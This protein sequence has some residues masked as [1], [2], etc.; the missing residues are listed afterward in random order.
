[1]YFN[2]L[3][4]LPTLTS[5]FFELAQSAFF[6]CAGIA[7]I[8]F[9]IGFHELGHFLIGRLC[10][11]SFHNFSIGFG[12]K[13]I[14]RKFLNTDFSISLIPLG[15]YVEPVEGNTAQPTPGTLAGTSYLKKMY[16]ILGGITF[17]LIFAYGAFVYLFTTGMPSNPF[18]A[19]NSPFIIQEFRTADSPAQKDGLLVNDMIIKANDIDVNKNISTL[20]RIIKENPNKP[21]KLTI[22]RNDQEKELITTPK[23][24]VIGNETVGSLEVVF[25]F[26]ALEPLSLIE[27]IKKAYNLT[28]SITTATALS[29]KNIFKKKST[30]GL[31][32]PLGMIATSS[33]TARHSFTQFLLLLAIIS[34]GLAVLN[35]IPLPILDGGQVVTYTIEA[36]IRRPINEKTK[37]A[38]HLTC[39][40]LMLTLVIFLTF[41]DIKMLWFK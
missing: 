27:S 18:T 2:F 14:S 7:G 6:I 35:V 11:L 12:P 4:I 19:N 23:E 36:L 22:I 33:Q 21:L 32:G 30:D 24:K 1:M 28:V 15:G 39:W 9:I 41:K 8:G 34:I 16:I 40:V 31:A 13:L 37:T 20:Q 38:I 26:K 17:N 10:G 25:S 3:T 29:F 5:H